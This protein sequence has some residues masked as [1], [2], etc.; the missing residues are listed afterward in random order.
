MN[1]SAPVRL[2]KHHVAEGFDCGNPILNDWLVRFALHNQLADA[3]TTFV[4]CLENRVIAFYSLAVGSI[5]H[6]IASLRIR[7]GPAN[8]PIPVMILARLAVDLEYQGKN[9]GKFLLKDAILRIV[10]ASEHFGIRAVL[11]HAKD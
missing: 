9:L 11:V 10:K 5:S 6:E 4:I 2:E 8:H 7:K 3:S 1:L